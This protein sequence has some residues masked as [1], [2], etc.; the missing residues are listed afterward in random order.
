[1]PSSNDWCPDWCPKNDGAYRDEM[2]AIKIARKREE[3]LAVLKQHQEQFAKII[4]N[5]YYELRDAVKAFY[6]ADTLCNDNAHKML[7]SSRTTDEAAK[8]MDDMFTAKAQM[9]KKAGLVK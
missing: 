6:E 2:S 3:A 9:Y 4:D 5:V 7:N 1:M 8:M